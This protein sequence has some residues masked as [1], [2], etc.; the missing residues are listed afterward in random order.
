LY[1]HSK[2]IIRI[3]ITPT[4]C[5]STHEQFIFNKVITRWK[6][7]LYLFNQFETIDKIGVGGGGI[8]WIWF[9]YWWTTGGY[10]KKC[11]Q[12][13]LTADRYYIFIKLKK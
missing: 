13:V 10:L 12:P 9:N 5:R 3:N 4:R 7:F 6:K 2:G 11:E 1:F 8:G